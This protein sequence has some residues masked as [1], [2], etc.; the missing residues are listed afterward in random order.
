M[1]G[2]DV[3]VAISLLIAFIGGVVMGIVVIVSI[4]SKREDRLGSLTGTAP[5]PSC[6]GTRWLT[7]VGVRGYPSAPAGPSH[8]EGGNEDVLGQEPHW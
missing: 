2:I 6:E 1:N 7:G 8:D 5:G 3:L 4:A